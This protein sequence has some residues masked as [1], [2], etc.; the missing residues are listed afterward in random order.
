MKKKLKNN[1]KPPTEIQ[2]ISYVSNKHKI[3]PVE[4][5]NKKYI[6]VLKNQ[7]KKSHIKVDKNQVLHTNFNKH[8]KSQNSKKQK[9]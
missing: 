3:T 1:S 6:N 8:T 5:G 9:Q 7:L 4:E 2:K